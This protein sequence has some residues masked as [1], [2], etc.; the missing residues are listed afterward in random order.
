MGRQAYN[1]EE[2]GPL[3]DLCRA[4]QLFEVQ[5]WVEDSKH[6]NPPPGHYRGSRK[7]TPLEY[8]IDAGF[9]SLVKVLLDAGADVGPID[10]YCPMT[11]A[12]EKRR[13]DIVKLLVEHGY[14]PT[15]VDARRVLST[16][17]PK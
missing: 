6:V 12:L 17:D 3:L 14:D 15:R 7:K 13:L 4:G 5:A 2:L 8:A 16:W 9:H 11:M 1:F 10:R